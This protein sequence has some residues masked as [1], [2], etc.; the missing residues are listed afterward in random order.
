MHSTL[1]NK[2][3]NSI[4]LLVN[5]FSF[6]F[7]KK[8]KTPKRHF[9]INRLLFLVLHLYGFLRYVLTLWM[10]SINQLNS[11]FWKKNLLQFCTQNIALA[12]TVRIYL[13]KVIFSYVFYYSTSNTVHWKRSNQASLLCFYD[14]DLHC[15]YYQTNMMCKHSLFK[16][17]F[18]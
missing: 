13:P 8:V 14:Q 10:I 12:P 1:K 4:L 2:W 15:G 7:W 17:L 16:K 18:M 5:L 9:K 3:T 11:Q 6:I